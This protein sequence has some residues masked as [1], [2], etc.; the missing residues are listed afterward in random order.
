MPADRRPRHPRAS[1]Q[2]VSDEAG[3]RA[4]IADAG[5][6]A[7][8]IEIVVV[9]LENRPGTGAEVTRKLA[10][11][12]VDLQIADVDRQ[13]AGRLVDVRGG[14]PGARLLGAEHQQLDPSGLGLL[15]HLRRD[16]QAAF[17]SPSRP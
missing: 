13:L 5:H 2:H 4:A 17:D 10:D 9:E 14:E 15:D 1:L 11:A 6:T 16:L 8:V 12:G 7:T 3:L